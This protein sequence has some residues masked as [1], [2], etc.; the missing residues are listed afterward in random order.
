MAF[1]RIREAF[2]GCFWIEQTTLGSNTSTSFMP[3]I[4][5]VSSA[6]GAGPA[7]GAATFPC[8]CVLVMAAV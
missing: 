8:F 2:R 7:V 5:S 3:A 6:T 4:I 1:S